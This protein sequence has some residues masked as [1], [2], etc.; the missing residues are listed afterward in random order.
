MITKSELIEYLK[1]T[2]ENTNYNILYSS[3]YNG[4][5]KETVDEFIEVLSRGNLSLAALQP[6]LAKLYEDDKTISPDPLPPFSVDKLPNQN[7]LTFT[8]AVTGSYDGSE[9]IT[10]EIPF[11]GG[12]AVEL[13]TTL[14]EAG[15][16]ADAKAVGDALAE[17]ESKEETDPTVPE[18]AKAATK[19][20]YTAEEVGARPADW[21]PTA[22]EVGALPTTY[23]PPDQTAEQ[24][25]ADPVGT[26][27]E[28]VSVHN[29]N[30][31]SHADIRLLIDGLTTRLNALANSTDEDLD[32]MAELVAYIKSNRSLIDS[33]TTSKVNV[34]DIVDNLTTNASAKPLSAA[35][36]V[37]LKELIDALSNSM[38]AY[39]TAAAQD[40]IDSGKVDKVTG[41]GLSSNDYTDAAKAKVDALA[42]VATSGSYD[43]LTNKPTIPAAY[44]DTE[45]RQRIGAIEAKESTWDAKSDFSGSYNDLTDKPVIPDAVTEG[46]VSGWGFTKNT[47]TYSKPTGGIPKADLANDV[48]ASL[49]KADTALQEHQSLAA[50]RTAAAQNVID[51]GKQDR[52][53]AGD[54][55]T[56]A[57][58]GKTISATGGAEA[59]IVTITDNN[60]TLS[61]NKS[62]TDIRDAILAGIS[63]LVVYAGT[64][65]PLTTLTNDALYFGTFQCDSGDASNGAVVAT[66]IIEI[67]QNNEVND[68]SAVVETLPNPNSITF[69]GAVTGSYDGSEPLSVDIPAVPTKTSQLTNDAGYLTLATLPKYEGVVE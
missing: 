44:D 56:I 32:Q 59:L 54:N 41:K 49:G 60:G 66:V 58:D 61:A 68:F 1:H 57:A 4:S 23:T 27:A 22:A 24:V 17:L 36:G 51:I 7:P 30:N 16:A 25:G 63:V 50:Y 65:L 55:I 40:V 19:P 28:A 2:P 53:I 52:L 10:V 67:T 39:R 20:S 12:S 47:G 13:D 11:S 18:W 48:K 6:Y 62:Y 5:N 42:P 26:A 34:A 37:A 45:V 35:Q 9:A 46:T 21:M 69:T 15:K 38:T 33:I 31:G 29:T 3:L 8:G 43:D 64:A 14:S